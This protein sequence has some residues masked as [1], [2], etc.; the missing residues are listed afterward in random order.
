M[1]YSYAACTILTLDLYAEVRILQ[2]QPDAQTGI[3]ALM[4]GLTNAT[5][6]TSIP[7]SDYLG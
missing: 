1:E 3:F 2:P 6:I 5:T 7:P 4:T